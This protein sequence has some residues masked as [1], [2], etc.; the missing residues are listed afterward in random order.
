MG[1]WHLTGFYGEL[2]TSKKGESWQ[3]M[4]H[5]YGTSDLPWH[6][7]GDFN[8]IACVEEKERGSCRWGIL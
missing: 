7:I 4:K 3:K 6:I 2:D 5:L 8:E 1:W